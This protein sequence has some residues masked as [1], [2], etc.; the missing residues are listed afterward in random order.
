MAVNGMNV[1]ESNTVVCSSFPRLNVWEI[2]K[3]MPELYTY[4]SIYSQEALWS[5][6][7]YMGYSFFL[8]VYLY[9]VAICNNP[10]NSLNDV[11]TM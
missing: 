2:W 3:I 6:V 1:P 9:T 7:V 4:L 5:I 8:S 10:A 11:T